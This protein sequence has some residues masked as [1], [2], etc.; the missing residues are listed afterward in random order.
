[1][2]DDQAFP[3]SGTRFGPPLPFGGLALG[4]W[5]AADGGA[6]RVLDASGKERLRLPAPPKWLTY[7][8]LGPEL[9]VTWGVP[10]RREGN[11][12]LN[13]FHPP[14]HAPN[15]PICTPSIAVTYTRIHPGGSFL[16]RAP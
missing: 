13:P 12:C 9:E 8:D 1:V 5:L 15:M 3:W 14:V 4:R 16:L 11:N 10:E 6:L 2:Q 7:R